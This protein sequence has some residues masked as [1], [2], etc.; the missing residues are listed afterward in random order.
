MIKFSIETPPKGGFGVYVKSISGNEL[1]WLKQ[2]RE[3]YQTD[4]IIRG[5]PLIHN[6]IINVQSERLKWY[7]T[8]GMCQRYIDTLHEEL[9]TLEGMGRVL[10][11]I[12]LKLKYIPPNE[13][14]IV[15]VQYYC[16]TAFDGK[17]KIT[18]WDRQALEKRGEAFSDYNIRPTITRTWKLNKAEYDLVKDRL[19]ELPIIPGNGRIMEKHLN[20]RPDSVRTSRK[21]KTYKLPFK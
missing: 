9:K 13:W 5:L 12:A 17:F 2:E 14:V 19:T 6:D 4:A 10:D 7:T 18:H 15:R 11:K 16:F 1:E 20:P 8:R 21:T 3:R